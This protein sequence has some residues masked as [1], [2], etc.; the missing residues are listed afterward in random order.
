MQEPVRMMNSYSGLLEEKCHGQLDEKAQRYLRFITESAQRMQKMIQDILNF[1]RVGREDIK[2]ER[3]DCNQIAGEIIAEFEE[4]IAQKNAR[5]VCGALPELEASPTLLRVLLQNLIGNALKFQD[6]SKTPEITI[7]A[8][9][10]DGMWEFS[11]RDNGIGINPD[12]RDKVF[13]IFQRIHRKEDYPGTGIGLSTCKKFI[14]LCGGTIGFE[15]IHGEGS[16]FTFTL[17]AGE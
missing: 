3:V 4:I 11:I 17:P 5:V 1:S 9:K 2:L 12:F 6:G 14:E 13:A 16:T 8:L 10:N 7:D 15:S